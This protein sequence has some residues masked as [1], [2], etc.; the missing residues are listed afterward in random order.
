MKKVFA[1]LL[2]ALLLFA[3]AGCAE[4]LAGGW[5]PSVSPEITEELR[6]VF[7]K[8][9]EGLV[10]VHYVPVAY[11]G[12]QVA[13]GTNHC[14]LAQAT[15][16]YPDAQPSYVLIFLYENLQGQ[17]ERMNIADFDFGA[18]CTY[19]AADR[20]FSSFE[21]ADGVSYDLFVITK[22]HYGADH[23]VVS[24]TGHYERV[25]VGEEYDVPEEAPDSE[26]T[27]N[28]AADFTADMV[29]NDQPG[30]MLV[31]VTD[32]YAWYIDAYLGRDNYDGHELVFTADLTKEEMDTADADFW[33]VTTRIELNGNDEIQYMEYV[34]VPWS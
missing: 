4:P 5:T 19:G 25:A 27:Y 6:A 15:V 8:G 10:G 12:S 28:L 14:F 18:L 26:R 2:A 11:L 33:F 22:M 17:V 29:D 32:L 20:K 23:Q 21:T 31:P 7:E 34:F 30:F 13:A 1:L 16:V 9:M 3:S 24:V